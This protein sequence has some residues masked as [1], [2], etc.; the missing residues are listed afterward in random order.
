MGN[1]NDTPPEFVPIAVPTQFYD[2]VRLFLAAMYEKV[3]NATEF[4]GAGEEFERRFPTDSDIDI[5]DD[6]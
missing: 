5:E 2:Y 1:T 6:W 4:L 3:S